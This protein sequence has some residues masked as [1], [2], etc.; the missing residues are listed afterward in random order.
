MNQYQDK[1]GKRTVFNKFNKKYGDYLYSISRVFVGFL[2]FSIG[3]R[4]L[5]GWF[6][7]EETAVLLSL[8]GLAGIIELLGGLAIA[9]GFF[10]RLTAAIGASYMLIE[11]LR[12]HFYDGLVPIMTGGEVEFLLFAAFL[13]LIRYGAQKWSLEKILLKKET[14]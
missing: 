7:G 4:R 10:T 3:A 1:R 13:V 2:F 14:F 11:Y 5:F 12:V 6:G 9:V 8:A